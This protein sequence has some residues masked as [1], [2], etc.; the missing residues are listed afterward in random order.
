MTPPPHSQEFQLEVIDRL[1]RIETELLGRNCAAHA[2]RLEVIEGRLNWYRGGMAALW[3]VFGV[4]AAVITWG[5]EY[6]KSGK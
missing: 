1:A 2:K 3:V 5:L 4:V 6:L